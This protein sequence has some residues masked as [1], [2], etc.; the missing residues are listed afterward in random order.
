MVAHGI[1]FQICTEDNSKF[2]P[3][4]SNSPS[5]SQLDTGVGEDKKSECTG[6]GLQAVPSR[7]PNKKQRQSSLSGMFFR[8]SFIPNNFNR[9]RN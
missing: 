7:I 6:P 1:F 3:P 8:I 5:R 4:F 2:V 9:N